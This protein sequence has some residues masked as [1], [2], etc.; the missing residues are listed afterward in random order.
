MTPPR[1]RKEAG[2]G[3]QEDGLGAVG[4]AA[5]EAGEDAVLGGDDEGVVRGVGEVDAGVPALALVD[6]A[7]EG[8]AAAEAPRRELRA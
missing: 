6:G 7:A 2:V 4:P 8:A 1:T 5:V 3:L